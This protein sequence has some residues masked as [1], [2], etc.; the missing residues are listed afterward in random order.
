MP[1]ADAAA[2]VERD[3]PRLDRILTVPNAI[4]VVRLACLPVFVWLLF[5]RDDRA[6]AAWLLAAIGTTDFA[7]LTESRAHGDMDQFLDYT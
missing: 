3:D 7:D 1:V 2:P 4:T 6:S 5:G